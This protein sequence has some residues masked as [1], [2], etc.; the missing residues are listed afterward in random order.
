MN[1]I[2]V[3]L[4]D[5]VSR[6][7]QEL[8]IVP[9]HLAIEEE[10][11]TRYWVSQPL[12]HRNGDRL[13]YHE[14]DFKTKPTYRIFNRDRC[15]SGLIVGFDSVGMLRDAN[16]PVEQIQKLVEW[17]DANTERPEEAAEGGA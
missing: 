13:Y 4:I 5:G 8:D 17:I 16:T 2:K 15:G 9:S 11:G 6:I 14:T 10:I 1:S 12:P 7:V 3:V